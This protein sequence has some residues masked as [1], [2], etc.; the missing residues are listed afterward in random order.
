MRKVILFFAV[1]L[2]SS[3]V[4]AQ[5][6]KFDK[7]EMLFSQRHYKRVYRKSARLLDKPEYDYSML[8]A[9]YR[10]ISTIQLA[11]NSFWNERHERALD[12]A[13][14]L[15]LQVKNSE[16]AEGIFNSHMYELA[17]VK[18]DMTTWASD[19]KRMGREEDFAKVQDLMVIM[20]DELPEAVLPEEIHVEPVVEDVNAPIKPDESDVRAVLV[21][22]AKEHIGTP[23]VWAG[24]S[25]DGFDCSGFTGY[26]MNEIGVSL[27]RRSQD[28][29]S[30]ATKVKKKNAQ[31]GD[32]VFFSN[33]SG[34]SHVGMLIS[35]KGESPVMIHSS[36][37]KGIIITDI[38][39]ST[40]WS[41]RL[42]GFGTF[43]Q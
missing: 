28:Q 18:T 35:E 33:G 31:K 13:K 42:Y 8:P 37:S 11:Q 34:V 20:F 17:W 7:L 15:F 32:L 25:P 10:S 5:V 14:E 16:H 27:P 39:K 29:Y 21:H 12:E 24:N 1:M 43:V 3:N 38:E 22:S 2:L 36:S 41:K 19:L 6:P 30:E 26:L 23:Y 4:E 40:Y 9:Y